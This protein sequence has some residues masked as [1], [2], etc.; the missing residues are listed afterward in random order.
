LLENTIPDKGSRLTL[1]DLGCGMGDL[2]G[3]LRDQGY[4]NT[5]YTG[6]D[7]VGDIVHAAGE[8]HP[9]AQ[10]LEG[11]F[12][13]DAIPSGDII[14]ASGSLNFIFEKAANQTAHIEK[15]IRKM[16][17]QA[18]YAAAFNLL[19]KNAVAASA[20]ERLLYYADKGHFFRFCQTL[21]ENALL[22]DGY[23]ANDFTI[24]MRRRLA[25]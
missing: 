9:A 16:W 7:L 3:Y 1:V 19:D 20:R 23:L 2:Y 4:V 22:V 21:C 6:L 15:V 12:L 13:T 14:C 24:V 10:F 18:G 17:E 25:P 11:N 8:K 5:G